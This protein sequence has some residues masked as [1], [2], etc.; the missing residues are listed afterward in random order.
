[1]TKTLN[2]YLC[3]NVHRPLLPHASL[4][5]TLLQ[6]AVDSWFQQHIANAYVQAS[7]V[8]NF[9]HAHIHQAYYTMSQVCTVHKTLITIRKLHTDSY[10][11]THAP[12]NCTRQV[13]YC[14]SVK[15]SL[16]NAFAM[17]TGRN[18]N[19]D[20]ATTIAQAYGVDQKMLC[21]SFRLYGQ[22]IS[23]NNTK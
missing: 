12:A 10:H 14:S 16:Y 8:H 15:I 3:N 13:L 4:I 7:N 21:V 6:Q 9:A 18:I 5:A 22:T 20:N 19:D 11:T 23:W 1:M 2:K 17:F